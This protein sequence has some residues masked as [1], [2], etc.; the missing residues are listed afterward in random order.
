MVSNV[1]GDQAGHVQSRDARTLRYA[2]TLRCGA[3]QDACGA[4]NT[5]YR[6][7]SSRAAAYRRVR[8]QYELLNILPKP[9][10]AHALGDQGRSLEY[11]VVRW[12][13]FAST[14]FAV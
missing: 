14:C 12:V 6:I 1:L 8:V 3:T 11:D 9:D 4:E 13:R 5:R 7:L 10:F 2:P